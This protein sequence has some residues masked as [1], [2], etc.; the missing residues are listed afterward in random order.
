M[1]RFL[2]M[3]ILALLS[4]WLP[5]QPMAAL[6]MPFCQ[7]GTQ[8]SAMEHDHASAHHTSHDSQHTEGQAGFLAC[9]DCGA[10]HL[11][12]APVLTVS[13]A[14]SGDIPTRSFDLSPP[15]LPAAFAPEQPHPPPLTH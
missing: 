5:L 9:S 12:C 2:A 8:P 4:G 1:R 6:A 11:A 7:H 10:C 3:L 13:F 14:L 15:L